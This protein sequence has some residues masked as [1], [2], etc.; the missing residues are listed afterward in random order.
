VIAIRR[1][2]TLRDLEEAVFVLQE[3]LAQADPDAIRI[4]PAYG[5]C[6]CGAWMADVVTAP[7]DGAPHGESYCW[8]CVRRHR[9]TGYTELTR[10]VNR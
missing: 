10:W 5:C 4:C 9:I 7:T 3:W 6:G 8:R 2:R 1:R